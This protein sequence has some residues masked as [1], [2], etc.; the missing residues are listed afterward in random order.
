MNIRETQA[1]IEAVLFAEGDAVELA[2]IAYAVEQDEETCR[3]LL[4]DME[5]RYRE[6]D[7]GIRLVELDGAWQLCTKKEY[8]DTLIRIEITAKKPR[9]TDIMLET[10]AIIAYKQPVTRLA[11]EQIRG[12]KSDHAVNRLIEYDLVREVG[13][14]DAPGRPVLL[15]TTEEFL[16]QFG[17]RSCQELPDMDPVHLADFQAEAEKEI[18]D[19]DDAESR[20]LQKTSD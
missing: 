2:R 5:L 17:L 11:I 10:L 3:K 15:G 19:G 13:R 7:R 14:V 18:G 16:R 9:L 20:I 4:R 12:V 8:Y 6:A 1:A